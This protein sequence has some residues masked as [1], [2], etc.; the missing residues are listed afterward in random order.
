MKDQNP[1]LKVTNVNVFK[2][3]LQAISTAAE[4]PGER[5]AESNIFRKLIAYAV[6]VAAG[7][8]DF[9]RSAAMEVLR[10]WGDKIGD[11]KTKEQ[12]ETLL[13]A[14]LESISPGTYLLLTTLHV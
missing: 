12:M 13:T 4:R 1:G 10:A 7:P 11:R 6:W 2:A 14:L 9:S 3:V 5:I 8:G